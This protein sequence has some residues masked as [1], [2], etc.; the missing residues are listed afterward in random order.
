MYTK[1]VAAVDKTAQVQN[2]M[3]AVGVT[4]ASG[5]PFIFMLNTSINMHFKKLL[6]QLCQRKYNMFLYNA[7]I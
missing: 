3:N 6:K 2:K 4:G 1:I 5:K 7:I